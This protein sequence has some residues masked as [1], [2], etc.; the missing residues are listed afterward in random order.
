MGILEN[1]KVLVMGI[2]NRW[3]LAW[4]IAGQAHVEGAAVICTCK[5]DDERSRAEKLTASF[6]NSLCINCDATNDKDLDRLR[7]TIAGRYGTIDGIVHSIAH[8]LKEDT[9]GS[10]LSTSRNGFAHALDVSTYSLIAVSRSLIDILNPGSSILT[11]TFMGSER[12][13]PGY[14]VMGIAKAALEAVVK[15]LAHDLGHKSIRVNGI[16]AGTVRTLSAKGIRDFDLLSEQAKKRSPLKRNVEPG[17]IAATALFLLS[18]LS[19]GITGE[20]IHTDCGFN[21]MGI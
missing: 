15:Y 10:I 9:D 18:P 2:R 12:V 1:K 8:A 5:T 16:S 11:L 3:S 14:N 6:G 13:F 7:E 4:A 21:I 19:K 17:E 20:I